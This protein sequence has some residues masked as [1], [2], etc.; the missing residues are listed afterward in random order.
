MAFTFAVETKISVLACIGIA[1]ATYAFGD[2]S[3][4]LNPVRKLAPPRV[5]AR[6][7]E[8]FDRNKGF[9]PEPSISEAI[10]KKHDHVD[11]VAIFE[12]AIRHNRFDVEG[13]TSWAEYKY[14][15]RF[16][17]I[18]ERARSTDDIL[19]FLKISKGLH[20]AWSEEQFDVLLN[21]EPDF[22]R[23]WALWEPIFRIP[24]AGARVGGAITSVI[25]YAHPEDRFELLRMIEAEPTFD[26]L[27]RESVFKQALRRPE[28]RRD[29]RILKTILGVPLEAL[30]RLGLILEQAG[31]GDV[32]RIFEIT[33]NLP[34]IA[35]ALKRPG[36]QFAA[37]EFG[38]GDVLKAVLG[39]KA[40]KRDFDLIREVATA[41]I[42]TEARDE[43]IS[44][45]ENLSA[46]NIRD[47]MTKHALRKVM[48]WDLHPL[49]AQVIAASEKLASDPQYV[50]KV[51]KIP[52]GVW[53][54]PMRFS[55]KEYRDGALFRP[56][57]RY[58]ARVLNPALALAIEKRD[59]SIDDA[60]VYDLYLESIAVSRRSADWN[61]GLLAIVQNSSR[62]DLKG[63][64]AL[65]RR[66][67]SPNDYT[68]AGSAME[69]ILANPMLRGKRDLIEHIMRH[70][71]R[72]VSPA[73]R[74][75]KT[76]CGA[77]FAIL[78][79]AHPDDVENFTALV[80]KSLRW[81]SDLTLIAEILEDPSTKRNAALLVESFAA[82]VKEEGLAKFR[83]KLAAIRIANRIAKRGSPKELDSSRRA[84]AIR[85]GRWFLAGEDLGNA[86]REAAVLA[87]YDPV[88][89]R[90]LIQLVTGREDYWARNKRMS[91]TNRLLVERAATILEKI[92]S[93]D[94]ATA[95]GGIGIHYQPIPSGYRGGNKGEYVVRE[96]DSAVLAELRE[97]TML[98]VGK[99]PCSS[100]MKAIIA[101]VLERSFY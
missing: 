92:Y 13:Q 25:K 66:E 34:S 32:Q 74:Q 48:G 82:H 83:A 19:A 30:S 4:L 38:N 16:K 22:K 72:L 78:E 96:E 41:P 33:N 44:M 10:L 2:Y 9:F 73:N 101:E 85:M 29:K 79:K 76:E 15:L 54:D 31:D 64:M 37:S 45:G 51:A 84:M 17:E 55:N 59:P 67:A 1:L 69:K 3:D 62:E 24:N 12:E 89:R 8:L 60:A 95:V 81:D 80:F 68:R 75:E 43:I 20:D 56:F 97:L 39:D 57:I 86:L 47:S 61:R 7:I 46:Q 14:R 58:T 87:Q 88:F 49:A 77:I 50:E 23:F 6:L 21:V 27:A 26:L 42:L 28:T 40:L 5:Q 53:A 35:Q 98:A 36:R 52:L 70:V 94:R 91:K 65:L 100:D 71:S 90:W 11:A 93:P 18:L 99:G 63:N